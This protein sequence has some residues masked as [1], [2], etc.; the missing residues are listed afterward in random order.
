MIKINDTNIPL[1]KINDI[2]I[3]NMEYK[4]NR[5]L[6]WLIDLNKV[7][8]EPLKCSD[9][10]CEYNEVN[11]PLGRLQ[12]LRDK[13]IITET[14]FDYILEDISTIAD[15]YKYEALTDATLD[16]M[17]MEINEYLIKNGIITY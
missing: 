11:L 9:I 14:E 5:N 13:N 3:P 10:L 8:I 15:K 6:K 17:V 16:S 1:I 7:K 2:N 12:I 4:F